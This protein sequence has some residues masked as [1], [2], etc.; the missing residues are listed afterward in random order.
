MQIFRD[1]YI[2]TNYLKTACV[3]K[4]NKNYLTKQIINTNFILYFY[5]IQTIFKVIRGIIDVK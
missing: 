5:L 1:L 4:L 2:K 3:E